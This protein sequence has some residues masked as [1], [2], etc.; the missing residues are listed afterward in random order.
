MQRGSPLIK[1][2]STVA[3]GWY[4]ACGDHSEAIALKQRPLHASQHA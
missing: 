4:S 1:E 3:S 2:A